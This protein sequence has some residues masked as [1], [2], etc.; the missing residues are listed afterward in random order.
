[1]KLM[2]K[3]HTYRLHQAVKKGNFEKAVALIG[4]GVDPNAQSGVN[5]KSLLHQLAD[6]DAFEHRSAVEQLLKQAPDRGADVESRDREGNMPLH[7]A[8]LNHPTRRRHETECTERTGPETPDGHFVTEYGDLTMA[9]LLLEQGV[10]PL[11]ENRQRLLPRELL[12]PVQDGDIR[13]KKLQD[14]LLNAE[15]FDRRMDRWSFPK[16][17]QAQK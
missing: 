7:R 2:D 5:R 16:N 8:I 11:L 13:R 15:S 14:W 9:E 4:K 12:G 6:V 3:L 10:N 17:R 1:M